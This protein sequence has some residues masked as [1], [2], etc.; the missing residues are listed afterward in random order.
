MG[1]TPRGCCELRSA[2]RQLVSQ[3]SATYSCSPLK[4]GSLKSPFLCIFPK[5]PCRTYFVSQG[6]NS[7]KPLLKRSLLPLT[8]VLGTSSSSRELHTSS[9]WCQAKKNF[10]DVLG[11]GKTASQKDIKKAYYQMAKKYHPDTNKNDPQAQ[12]KFQEVSEAY[13]ILSDESKRKQYDQ[14]GT[15]G[16]EFPGAAPGGGGPRPGA[17]PGGGFQYQDFSGHID[18]EELFRRIFGNAAFTGGGGGFGFEEADFTDNLQG[19]ARTQ[20]I[21]MDLTFTQA[22]RGINKDIRVNV[23]DTCPSCEGTKCA[24]GTKPVKCPNCSGTGM[25]TVSTGPFVMR[26]TCRQCRGTR[27][28]IKNPCTE[29]EGKGKTVQRK[30]I[31]VP[32]PPGVEDGQ[33]IRM[34]VGTKEIFVTFRVSKSDIFRRDGADVHSDVEISI[35]QAV[36]GGTMRVDGIYDD[37]NVDIPPGTSSH[38]KINLPGKGI[39]KVN[40]HGYGDHYLH[41]KIKVPKK[42]NDR[43]KALVSAYAV[44]EKIKGTVNVSGV[45]EDTISQKERGQV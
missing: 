6:E 32:V 7:L 19:F 20:E 45:N 31:T 23:T 11:V 35:G 1:F 41:I 33:T 38:T 10:Y 43:Q 13:E 15:A 39:K 17:A 8:A 18:P 21:M 37:H 2:L 29:C 26:S 4:Y 34:P 30:T 9:S 27:V 25:E 24:P 40:S 28:Y 5:Q 22:A 3:H 42:M 12:K 36:L 44:T 14:W 16:N